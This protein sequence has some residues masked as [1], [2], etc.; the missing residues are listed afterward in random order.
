MTKEIFDT[1]VDAGWHLFPLYKTKK[2]EDQA[3]GKYATPNGW[4]D[5]TKIYKYKENTVYGGMPPE[6]VI[7]I[8]VDVKNGKVGLNSFESMSKDFNVLL[9]CTTTTPSGGFHCY[10]K[11]TKPFLVKKLQ[12]KYPDIDFLVRGR[13]WAM[14]GGQ[15]VDG[16]GDY[17]ID[18]IFGYNENSVDLTGL[19]ERGDRTTTKSDYDEEDLFNKEM[20]MPDQKVDI[21]LEQIP[22]ELAYSDWVEVGMSLYDRYQGNDE[23]RERWLEFVKASSKHTEGSTMGVDKWDKG[24]LVPQGI[25]YIRL[26]NMASEFSN[27]FKKDIR[28]AKTQKSLNKIIDNISHTKN[29]KTRN[30]KDSDMRDEFSVEINT[31][32]KELKKDNPSIKVQQ[33]RTIVKELDYKMSEDEVKAELGDVKTGLYLHGN[34]YVLQIGKKMI[35]D[36]TASTVITHLVNH[37]VPPKLAK[38]IGEGKK[39]SISGT[40]VSTDYLLG[41][42]IKYYVESADAIEKLPLLVARKDPFF[43]VVDYEHDDGI[44][45]EFFDNVWAGKAIDIIEIIALSIKFSQ[46]K[47][48]RLMIVA[49]SDTGKTEICEMLG[50]QKITMQRLLNG[51][52]G[53]KGVGTKVIDGIKAS[54]LLLV[55]ESNKPLES[56][57][58][59][60]DK[61]LY[62]DEFGSGGGTQKIKLHFTTLTSTHKTATR[63]NSDEL[64]NRFLQI[65]LL[66]TESKHTVTQGM[67]YREDTDKYSR[68]V[69]SFMRYHFKKCLTDEKYDKEY[70]HNLQ[71]KY[72]L[73]LNSDLDDLLYDIGQDFM[74]MIEGGGDNYLEK[75]GLYYAKRKRDIKDQLTDWITEKAPSIDVPKF[76]EKMEQHFIPTNTRKTIKV[77]G[78]PIKFHTLNMKPF[79]L[80]LTEEQ[81]VI[82]E[83][84]D[85][86]IEFE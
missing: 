64:Y 43:N 29:V 69:K 45:E 49:P 80:T 12:D 58:K 85:L 53:D 37:K 41:A 31:K 40:E 62:V 14:L 73:P 83:F 25:T 81:S 78:K 66:Q 24:Y 61:T 75:E 6:D 74:E 5:L 65:E 13:E 77:D 38:Q 7:V 32:L 11:L 60:M 4:N 21:Y 46:E 71:D 70:L 17:E 67:L 48:N 28:E 16:Y 2:T 44:L 15:T 76:V 59:D 33:A 54:G 57:I 34:K 72:R 39:T 10:V 20:E 27:T 9:S 26:R 47:L 50:F 3:K 55:D 22:K 63:N 1:Y 56:E 42:E 82:D 86:S 19:E 68:V 8:D 79:R 52:K 84:D 18:D 23:G 36:L 30:K 35:T 51:L